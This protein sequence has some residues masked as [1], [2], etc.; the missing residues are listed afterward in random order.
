MTRQNLVSGLP[1]PEARSGRGTTPR[2]HRYG[3][4]PS[5]FADLRVPARRR[6]IGTV[7]LIHGGFW[8][9]RYGADN[10]DHLATL[11]DIDTERVVAIGHSAGGHLATWAAGLPSCRQARP[12]PGR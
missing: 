8:G 9:P 10:L 4:D 6:R 11:A 2:R 3:S 5:Q 12:V 1:N 7:V